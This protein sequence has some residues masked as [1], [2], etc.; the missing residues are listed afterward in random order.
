MEVGLQVFVVHLVVSKMA[1]KLVERLVVRQDLEHMEDGIQVN[2]EEGLGEAWQA[3]KG[4]IQE[5]V[6]QELVHKVEG[7]YFGAE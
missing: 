2:K 5:G 6:V 7:L 3:C 1:G 4:V